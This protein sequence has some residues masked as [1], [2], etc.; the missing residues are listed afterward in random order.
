MAYPLKKLVE[1]F[2]YPAFQIIKGVYT[3]LI[4]T[5]NRK[6]FMKD[7]ARRLRVSK[8]Q[9]VRDLEKLGVKKGDVLYVHS[10]LRSIGFVQGGP[11]TVINAM[12][13]AVG[14]NGT[15]VLPAFSLPRSMLDVVRSGKIFN[16]QTTPCTIG[17]IPETFR[18][19]PGV[20]RSIHP[21]HS[22]CA[23]GSKA[24]W[25][26]SGHHRCTTTFGEGTPYWKMIALNAKVMG[27]GVDLAYP[28]F[29]HT[30]EDIT[31]RFPLEVYEK[32]EYEVKVLD[33]NQKEM[34]MKVRPHS[35]DVSK[36][37]IDQPQGEFIRKYITDY[38]VSRNMLRLGLVGEAH[39]WLMTA[40]DLLSCLKELMQQGITIY[41][42]KEQLLSL[43]KRK[44]YLVKNY[45]SCHSPQAFDYLLEEAKQTKLPASRKGFW[46]D[47]NKRWIRCL[48][49]NGS[50]WVNYVGHD[51]KFA[52]ELQEGATIFGMTTGISFLDDYLA[53]EL[54][55]IHSQI[56]HN[57]TI[58]T[59]PDA[60][61]SATCE[62]GL[63]MSTLALGAKYFQNTR[64]ALAKRCFEDMIKVSEY[65]KNTWSEAE[66]TE[67][68]SYILRGYTNAWHTFTSYG[69]HERK[70]E[71]TKE[72]KKYVTEYLEEQHADGSFP[73]PLFSLPVQVQEKIDI[74]LLLAYPI[75]SYDPCL[76]GVKRNVEWILAKRWIGKT[77]GLAWLSGETIDRDHAMDL[78]FE[79]HQMW[80]MIVLR[81]LND[82]SGGAYNYINYAKNAWLFLT[83]N[84]YTKV[85]SFVHN[86]QRTGAFFSYRV[87]NKNG[88]IQPG[89]Q[90]LYKG[91]YEIGASLWS[92]ALNYEL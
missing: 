87:I 86:Y 1:R 36:T 43:P 74:A 22:V 66:A 55:Y 15:L 72:I 56:R 24:E 19:R 5:R 25:I 37:R 67:D 91:A 83:D 76:W 4:R 29:Y 73:D 38:L 7:L 90:G 84:N 39:C 75:L 41:T 45:R 46:D 23:Y 31:D 40:R 44:V 81:Y 30:F 3:G 89:E 80:F 71:M 12:L 85:D 61:G 51:W 48:N 65:V 79:C 16:P 49:W 52:L 59:I 8:V 63:V 82:F 35:P 77:G 47:S 60:Y 70:D 10:S 18:K 9:I 92:L 69:D 17:L 14:P 20:F 28:T 78:F 88:E 34:V 62:Y 21:T 6:V 68:H 50:D 26:T 42:T 58:S 53:K 27:L 57:G 11:D 32:K 33:E 54:E 2:P 13:E 64:E